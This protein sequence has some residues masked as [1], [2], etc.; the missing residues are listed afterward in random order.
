MQ[1]NGIY[2]NCPGTL[3]IKNDPSELQKSQKLLGTHKTGA[4]AEITLGLV[5]GRSVYGSGVGSE[6]R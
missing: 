3:E 5:G 1:G 6:Q 2:N 4:D